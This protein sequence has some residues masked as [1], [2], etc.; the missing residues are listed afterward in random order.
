[1]KLFEIAWYGVLFLIFVYACMA[2]GSVSDEEF[3]NKLDGHII[4]G[5][6][7]IMF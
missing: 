6:P 4:L 2:A 3:N 5:Q 1:M 7:R